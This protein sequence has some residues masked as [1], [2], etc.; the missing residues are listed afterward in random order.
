MKILVK[1]ITQ[2]IRV[3][4]F[5]NFSKTRDYFFDSVEEAHQ[6]FTER[7]QKATD[8]KHLYHEIWDYEAKIYYWDYKINNKLIATD[9]C[10]D[11]FVLLIDGDFQYKLTYFEDF[12]EEIWQPKLT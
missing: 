7:V 5:E 10:I 1:E 6:F 2:W 12:S 8:E 3:S 4:S 11:Y 9:A